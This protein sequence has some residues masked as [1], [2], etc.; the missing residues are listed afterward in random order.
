MARIWKR[1]EDHRRDTRKSILE[2]AVGLSPK[3][4]EYGYCPIHEKTTGVDMDCHYCRI[5]MREEH[6]IWND[7]HREMTI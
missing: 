1:C 6:R 7:T 2:K 5:V 3:V 4:P